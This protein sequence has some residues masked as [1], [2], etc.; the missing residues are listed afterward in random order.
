[1]DWWDGTSVL[2]ERLFTWLIGFVPDEENFK[3]DTSRTR[4]AKSS[5]WLFGW[6]PELTSVVRHFREIEGAM[7]RE[8]NNNPIRLLVSGKEYIFHII[9]SI[10][11]ADHSAERKVE[12]NNVVGYHRCGRCSF[13]FHPTNIN[14]LFHFGH[15]NS[16]PRKTLE[17]AQKKFATS[18]G[19]KEAGEK[20]WKAIPAIL[21]ND[22]TTPLKELNLSEYSVGP[23]NLHT[24]KGVTSLLLSLESQRK[25]WKESIFIDNLQKFLSKTSMFILRFLSETQ[26]LHP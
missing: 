4:I 24:G 20:G 22:V 5:P 19:K 21:N 3:P 25:G 1:M 13:N 6:Y 14:N 23:D 10:G 7:L 15:T 18:S 17:T 9:P 12:G 16:L 8:F 26:V 11:K 2:G